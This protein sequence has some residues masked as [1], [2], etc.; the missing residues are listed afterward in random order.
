MK[1]ALWAADHL[2]AI[3]FYQDTF[4][5]ELSF[6][7]EVWS[8][9]T[10]CGSTLGIH[11]GGEGKRTWTGLSFQCDEIREGIELVKKN[12]GN[13]VREPEEE[14][15]FI[16]L[17]FCYDTEGNEFM[18]TQKRPSQKRPSQNVPS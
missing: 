8:E 17:A 12:G 6:E 1:Y 9:L 15:G 14:D 3:R 18:L 11:G 2:R 7:M 10:L 13:L 4:G 16:H 5:A